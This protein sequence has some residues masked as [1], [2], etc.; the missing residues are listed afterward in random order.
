MSA[1]FLS[2][3]ASRT[4]DAEALDG[5]NQIG[6]EHLSRDALMVALGAC[7]PNAP[8]PIA[9]SDGTTVAMGSLDSAGLG[10]AEAPSNAD[11][12]RVFCVSDLHT[13]HAANL[14]WCRAL[15][16]QPGYKH[17]TLIVAGDVTSSLVLLRET[18]ELCL[19][20]FAHVFYVPGNHDL[21]VKGSLNSGGLHVRAKPITS[22]QKLEEIGEMCRELGVCTAPAY[23]GGAIIAPV[24]SWY[25]A[26][27]DRE[28]DVVGWD[29]IHPPELMMRDFHS[30]VFPPPLR[31]DNDSIARHFD[32]LNDAARAP[33]GTLDSAI[34][35]LR[36]RHPHAPLITFS[37]FV[38]LPELYPEKRYLFYPPLAKMIGSV[39][40]A[41]RIAALRPSVHVFGHTHFGWDATI[42]GV[43]YLQ[44]PLSYPFEREE[45]LGSVALGERFPH[46]ESP[47][48]V[49][50]Y[51]GVSRR[52]PPRYDAGWSNFYARYP[53]R[54]DLSHIVA[55]Y[56]A[57]GLVRAPGGVGE[58]G[59][60]GDSRDPQTGARLGE[61]QPAWRLGPASAIAF[62][63]AQRAASPEL[64]ARAGGE[65]PP[66]ARRRAS[67]AQTRPTPPQP[68]PLREQQP[69][70]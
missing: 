25:H 24:L 56:V 21:W 64:Y 35:E 18:L 26:S 38:P 52:F 36:A 60:F 9:R 58:V 47:A 29:G 23:A 50:V 54:A 22:L 5:H 8:V 61:P 19:R 28:P 7:V 1:S 70:R 45:R 17:D 49:L 68:S 13:D 3:V 59:W 48:P 57:A 43:R 40:L 31:A 2:A 41:A 34:A 39:H 42:D 10:R 4:S 66:G 33:S 12:G 14:E 62:E 20:A 37:H 32:A 11:A 30:C 63:E 69:P 51:D 44:A 67:K 16:D 27:W 55:P 53:R 6:I 46:G 65:S 15:S